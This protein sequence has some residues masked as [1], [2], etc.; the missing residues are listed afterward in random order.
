MSIFQF[1]NFNQI[2]NLALLIFQIKKIYKLKNFEKN[3]STQLILKIY[4]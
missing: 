1:L 3:T 4:K 2:I